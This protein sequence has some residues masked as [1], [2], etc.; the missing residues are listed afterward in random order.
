M[1][2]SVLSIEILALPVHN[3]FAEENIQIEVL[4]NNGVSLMSASSSSGTWVQAS[5]GNW[6]YKHADGS[7]TKYNWEYI[8]GKWY[9]FDGD[10]WMRSDQWLLWKN[11]WYYLSSSGAR[12]TGWLLYKENWY[13]FNS[14]GVM[15]TG[16]IKV[17]GKEYF[18]LEDGRMHTG[19]LKRWNGTFYLNTDGSMQ[20]G[21]KKI[22]GSWYYFNSSGAMR[23]SSLKENERKYYFEDSGELYRT[24]ML[25]ER[26]EQ[27]D[28]NWCWA[29]CSAMVGTYYTDS[30]ITQ[31]DI[32]KYIKGHIVS[33]GGDAYETARAILYASKGTKKPTPTLRLMKFN[34]AVEKIDANHPFVILVEYDDNAHSIV[35]AGY[36]KNESTVRIIDP[37]GSTRTKYYTYY[38]V[39]NRY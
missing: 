29:A 15:E 5:N 22:S 35:C 38:D 32:V 21:W 27:Q 1:I 16:W 31:S 23:T 7:Y 11:K 10:G 36:N 37:W 19:W 8:D 9:F 30:T 26:Q 34:E 14:D 12:Y 25:I 3:A 17:N 4:D 18:L 24:E 39:L 2:A 33:E 13:Y 20:V 6:W 28:I